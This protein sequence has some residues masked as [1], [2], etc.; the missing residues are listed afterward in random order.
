MYIYIKG[1]INCF[2][3]AAKT[4]K[5]EQR[6]DKHQQKANVCSTVDVTSPHD[7][8]DC[9]YSIKVGILAHFLQPPLP[10]CPQRPLCHGCH[11]HRATSTEEPKG[12]GLSGDIHAGAKGKTYQIVGVQ[13]NSFFHFVS[14]HSYKS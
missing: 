1:R 13:N 3:L 7:R 8:R 12:T 14:C 9:I 5:L 10:L 11:G 6:G 4:G 2:S